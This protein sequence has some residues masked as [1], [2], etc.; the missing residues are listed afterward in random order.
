MKLKGLIKYMA[1]RR[2]NALISFSLFD[3]HDKKT[4]KCQNDE[5]D[6]RCSFD[7]VE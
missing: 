3:S 2:E 7:R 4:R 5:M 6:H 1:L